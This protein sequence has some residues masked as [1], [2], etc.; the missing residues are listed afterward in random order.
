MRYTDSGMSTQF[1]SQLPVYRGTMKGLFNDRSYFSALPIT[2]DVIVSDIAG[3]TRAVQ[4]GLYKEVNLV[5]A[6]AVIAALNCART[7]GIE[8]PFIFGGDGATLACPSE[9]TETIMSELKLIQRNARVNFQLELRVGSVSVVKLYEAGHT[10]LVARV[11]IADGYSQAVCMGNGLIVA[12]QWVKRDSAVMFS[13]LATVLQADPNLQG[14]QCRWKEVGVDMDDKEIVSL[15][16]SPNVSED[17]FVVFKTMLETIEQVYGDYDMRHPV[18]VDELKLVKTFGEV[19]KELMMKYQR[20]T[21]LNCVQTMVQLVLTGYAFKYHFLR[22]LFDGVLYKRQLIAAT[23]TLK[24]DGMLKTTIKGTQLQRAQLVDVL[25]K[26]EN[27]GVIH[28][29]YH[30]SK[31]T[32]LTCYV[33]Q[34]GSGHLHFLDSVGGGYTMSARMLKDKKID[35]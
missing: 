29:G 11:A 20:R 13:E 6:S 28:F 33:Y 27:N 15:V 34:R 18:T 10:I 2:W 35:D 26:F 19:K 8:I 12:E 16:I 9:L 21:F 1:Y 5:A 3:S 14:L 23:D 30:V 32:V 31:S 7:Q 17:Q 24:I 4:N 25:E 22:P